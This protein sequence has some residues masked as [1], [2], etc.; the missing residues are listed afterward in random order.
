MYLILEI[1]IEASGFLFLLAI[2]PRPTNNLCLLNNVPIL[3]N[4]VPILSNNV[5]IFNNVT[6]LPRNFHNT[7]YNE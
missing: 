6:I 1:I 7:T 3:L 4:N 2:I 5:T